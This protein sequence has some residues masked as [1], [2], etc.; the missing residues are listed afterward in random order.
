MPII[1]VYLHC[2]VIWAKIRRAVDLGVELCPKWELWV[3]SG[4]VLPKT[5][6]AVMSLSENGPGPMQ[7]PPTETS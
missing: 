2:K 3:H 5:N 4:E 6:K 7:P 1:Y